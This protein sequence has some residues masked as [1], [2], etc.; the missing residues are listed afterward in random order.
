MASMPETATTSR[1]M[2]TV[3]E[4]RHLSGLDLPASDN[5]VHPGFATAYLSAASL[6]LGLAEVVYL[7]FNSNLF[8]EEQFRPYQ[9]RPKGGPVPKTIFEL[10]E[11][12]EDVSRGRVRD[13]FAADLFKVA[14]TPLHLN[15]AIPSSSSG[16]TGPTRGLAG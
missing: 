8:T 15:T 16:N 7:T 5:R 12:R 11:P 9:S 10:C 6:V 14:T 2:A 3:S 4:C 1:L 13:E